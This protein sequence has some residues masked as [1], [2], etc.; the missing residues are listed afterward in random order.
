MVCMT[1]KG[2]T[3]LSFMHCLLRAVSGLSQYLHATDTDGEPALRNATAARMQNAT[4]LLCYVH[5]K[6]NVE[7]TLKEL[8]SSKSLTKKISILKA[9]VC[10]GQ[11]LRS[12]PNDP[13]HLTMNGIL[14][15][16]QRE[17]TPNSLR[18]TFVSSNWLTL[19]REWWSLPCETWVLEQAI[20]PEGTRE[21]KSH[22]KRVDKLRLARCG[23][24]CPVNVQLCRV[25]WHRNRAS[26][27]RDLW[28]VGG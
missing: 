5:S 6:R 7:S 12:L 27:V 15:S 19:G 2:A 17:D 23:Q 21:L 24:I 26:L 8:G 9:V 18:R 10:C 20:P 1:K 16:H 14:S 11:I 28:Q 3:Y 13:T 22:D 4:A 25:L